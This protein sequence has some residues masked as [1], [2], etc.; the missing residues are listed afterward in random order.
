MTWTASFSEQSRQSSLPRRSVPRFSEL[1]PSGVRKTHRGQTDWN[2]M[3]LK[4]GVISL[5]QPVI[6]G[7][8]Q[9]LRF[10]FEIL[11]GLG[12]ATQDHSWCAF[13]GETARAY[14]TRLG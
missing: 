1:R 12:F 4:V 2:E 5:R 8:F 10:Q 9:N 3:D 7:E 13:I 11:Q 14:H 6:L